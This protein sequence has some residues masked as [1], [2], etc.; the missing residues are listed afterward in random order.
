[1]GLDAQSQALLAVAVRVRDIGM[2]A[3][4]DSVV[5]AT[6]PL[7]P[8][9]WELINRHPVIGERLLE[10]LFVMASAAEIVRAHHERWDGDGYPDGRRGDA[11]PLLSRVIA[12]CDVSTVRTHLHNVYARLGVDD[13]AQAVLRATEMGWL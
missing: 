1:M 12:T 7:S 8:A 11:I 13:R 2:V 3:L 5:L 9:D 10:R 4:P 6:T